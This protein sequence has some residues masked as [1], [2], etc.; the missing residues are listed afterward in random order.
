MRTAETGP[1]LVVAMLCLLLLPVV[2]CRLLLCRCRWRNCGIFVTF[3]DARSTKMKQ[4]HLL[5]GKASCCGELHIPPAMAEYEAFE[6][7]YFPGGGAVVVVFMANLS[8]RFL[9][10]HS[11]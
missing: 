1:Y 2:L 3:W 5:P 11:V 10:L 9:P 7:L 4:M 6:E 8:A